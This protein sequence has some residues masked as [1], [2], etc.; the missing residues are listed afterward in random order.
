MHIIFLET[1]KE[2]GNFELTI[3]EGAEDLK[4]AIGDK[5]V[6]P[7]K[8]VLTKQQKEDNKDGLMDILTGAFCLQDFEGS[9]FEVR[10]PKGEILLEYH[11][12]LYDDLRK[13]EGCSGS[14]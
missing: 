13:S 6:F 1:I 10:N 4:K 9:T 2:D 7:K 14:C 3:E 8:M 12:S 5:Y 11:K